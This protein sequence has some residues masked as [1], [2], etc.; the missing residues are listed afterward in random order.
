[1]HTLKDYALLRQQTSALITAEPD[2]T[3]TLG[4][5]AALVFASVPELN[6]VGF[7]RVRGR[8]L[9]L[10]PFQGQ[11]ACTRIALG[12]GVCGTAAASGETQ[13]VADVH[14]FPGHIACDAAS[15][16]ELVIPIKR[17]AQVVAVFDIDSPK[18]DRF[19]AIDQEGLELIG[20]D[21]AALF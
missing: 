2:R 6:W 20:S 14:A 15:A 18:Q 19:S 21:L 11:V 9:V 8:E 13:R 1:M 7:Y 5:V 17:G 4:N 16:S 12:A 10:G 3:A